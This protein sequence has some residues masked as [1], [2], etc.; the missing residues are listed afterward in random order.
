M[1]AYENNSTNTPIQTQPDIFCTIGRALTSSLDPG[2]VFQRVMKVIGKFFS[3]R[4]WSLLLIEEQTGRLK[5]EIVMGVDANKL[6]HVYLEPGEGIAGWVCENN[7]PVVA[8]DVHKDSRLDFTTH[9]VICVPLLNGKNKVIGAIELINK[10]ST[11]T[12][13]TNNATPSTNNC[14]TK[15]DLAILSSIGAFTGV[16][17]ENA[18]LHERIK[19]L[20][21][22]DS[23]TGLNNRHYFNEQ[24]RVET[25]R[26]KRYDQPICVLMIDV[27]N[28][29][30]INDRLGHL[31]GDKALCTI[32][33][34]LKSSIRESD[35]LARFGGDEFVI[36][37]PMAGKEKGIELKNRIQYLM[38]KRNENPPIPGIRLSAS[39]GIHAAM[40]ENVQN[41]IKM[42]DQEL[43]KNKYYRKKAEELTAED[44]I[45]Q[46]LWK[47]ISEK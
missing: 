35:V 34:I 30:T 42:A 19:E 1:K 5:F 17:A 36:L 18:F 40:P 38:D 7:Q 23:L 39:I 2:E 37:M 29:K 27:D 33:D 28:L 25:E 26:V 41:L 16:A 14:F 43:Y 15:L 44:Q 24:F 22:I 20:A 45:K 3:P 47:I 13:A 12:N 46:Y 8:E 4:N 32:A 9:S 6:K 31:T 10:I 21:M 11:T